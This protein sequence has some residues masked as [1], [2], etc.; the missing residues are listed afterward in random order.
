MVEPGEKRWRLGFLASHRGTNMQAIIDACNSG[1][2]PAVPVVVVS[3]SGSSGALDRAVAHGIPTCV[4][5]GEKFREPA[6]LDQALVEVLRK[7]RV[8][9]VVLAGYMKK[10]GPMTLSAFPRRI[11]N[12]HPALL[13]AHGGRGMYGSHVHSAVIAAGETE[14]GVTIHLVDTAYDTGPILAQCRIPVLKGDT[15]ES[16]AARVLPA[17]H[18]LY[19]ETLQRIMRGEIDLDEGHAAKGDTPH[20]E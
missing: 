2:L 19:V 3:N 16:L 13:P 18:Q 6:D 10:I 20:R 17:E 12:V 8:D 5:G 14:T 15:A 7:Y 9:L 4:L 1:R 11:V